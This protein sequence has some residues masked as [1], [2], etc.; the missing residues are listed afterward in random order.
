LKNRGAGRV[1]AKYSRLL[2]LILSRLRD[3][4]FATAAFES[5]A[6]AVAAGILVGL[7]RIINKILYNGAL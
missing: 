1:L 3:A 4:S 6:A 5:P 2:T 7:Y